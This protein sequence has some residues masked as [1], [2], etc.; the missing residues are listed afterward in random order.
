MAHILAVGIATLDVINTLQSYPAEDQEVRALSQCQTRGGNAT[1]TLV[2]LSQLGH[3]CC[4]AGMLPREP[5]AQLVITDL[6]KYGVDFSQTVR[7]S[8]GKLP[9]SYITLSADSGSRSIVHFRDCPEY[10]FASFDKLNLH[11]YDWI[12]FEGRNVQ[13]LEQMLRKTREAG[14]PCS[15]EVEKPR[16][17]IECLFDLPEV[18]VFSRA[19]VLHRGFASAPVFLQQ[20]K[21]AGAVF[22]AWG[23]EGGWCRSVSGD[24]HHESAP[25]IPVIDSLGAGD[26][27]NAALIDSLIR[28]SEPLVAL[29]DAVGLASAQCAKKGL[30]V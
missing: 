19:Y 29:R 5:D 1:N 23:E 12:H 6:K 30:L 26:V 2:V 8:V 3:R 15:L 9:T 17:Q 27:F 20:L 22:V 4:W 14:I 16:E 21:F 10:D 28:H 25:Q 24:T 18:L 7:P 13:D 11:D